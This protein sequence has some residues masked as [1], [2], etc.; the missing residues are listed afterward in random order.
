MEPDNESQPRPD[1]TDNKQEKKQGGG[2]PS[3]GVPEREK[4]LVAPARETEGKL[5]PATGLSVGTKSNQSTGGSQDKRKDAADKKRGAEASVLTVGER[6]SERCSM[7]TN[8]DA[9]AAE[10]LRGKNVLDWTAADVQTWVRALPRG[11]AAF[12]E[13]E[14]FANGWVDGKKL[15]TLTLSDIKRKEF[16]HAKFKAKVLISLDLS[17]NLRLL[18]AECS[19]NILRHRLEETG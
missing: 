11:L 16:R 5:E 19:V 15:A 4:V 10:V 8:S 14:A 12:A 3:G 1:E 9:A 18:G 6:R 17:V 13:A 7:T 2:L